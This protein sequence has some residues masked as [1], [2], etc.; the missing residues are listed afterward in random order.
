MPFFSLY[1][2]PFFH[3]QLLFC[4]IFYLPFTN[5][6]TPVLFFSQTCP[7]LVLYTSVARN[8]RDF[9]FKFQC[10]WVGW[11]FP[12][13]SIPLAT[14]RHS[15][16]QNHLLFFSFFFYTYKCNT[17]YKSLTYTVLFTMTP[18]CDAKFSTSLLWIIEKVDSAFLSLRISKNDKT[19]L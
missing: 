3:S 16:L 10:V 12:F 15:M 7:P 9:P 17:Y 5:L 18:C 4:W 14:G 11:Q 8:K 19:A 1:S 6:Q 13:P 2:L